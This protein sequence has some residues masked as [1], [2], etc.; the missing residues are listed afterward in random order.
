MTATSPRNAVDVFSDAF[1]HAAGH[2]KGDIRTIPVLH[3]PPASG[4][5]D[6]VR[7]MA[8]AASARY[9]SVGATSLDSVE[10][11]IRQTS[12]LDIVEVID[13]SAMN[14]ARWDVLR[15]LTERG[16]VSVRKLYGSGSDNRIVPVVVM[17]G[18][19][20]ITPPRGSD[21]RD[22]SNLEVRDRAAAAYIAIAVRERLD[23]AKAKRGA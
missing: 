4:K 6:L 1:I 22:V 13:P 15:T 10:G 16:S 21:S 12:G 11:F 18:A 17:T 5:S 8:E 14:H 7:C 19:D 23:A 3:G 9:G 2:G 20:K